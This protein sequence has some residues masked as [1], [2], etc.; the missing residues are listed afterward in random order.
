MYTAVERQGADRLARRRARWP[1]GYNSHRLYSPYT[2]TGWV[3]K[4]AL[5]G[6]VAST[7]VLTKTVASICS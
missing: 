1:V 5:S 2:L 3:I 6:A 4:H 7:S